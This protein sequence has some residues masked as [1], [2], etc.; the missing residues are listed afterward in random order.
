[1]NILECNCQWHFE[2]QSPRSQEIGPNNAAAEHFSAT[3]YPSLIRESIQNSLDVVRDESQPVKMKFE[4]GKM[5]AKTYEAFYEL[6]RHIEGVLRFYGSAAES[7]Y[8]PMLEHFEKSYNNQN[9]LHYIKVSDYNTVGMDYIHGDNN[10]PLYAFLRAEGV[11]VK[12]NEFSGGSF[13]FGKS[14][15]FMISPIHTVLVSTMT[16][17]GKSF[18]EGA[19]RL[20][21]HLY[22]G[23]DGIEKKYQHYGYYDNQRGERPA[24]LPTDIPKKFKRD[25]PGT[26]FYIMGMDGDSANQADAYDQMIKSTLRH[27][28]MAVM[29]HKLVVEIGDVLIDSD[30]LDALM[31][32]HFPSMLDK[33]RN[34]DEYNPRPYYEAV[35]NAGLNKNFVLVEKRLPYLGDAKL[36][37]W[38]NKEARDGV[39]H[40]RKQRMFIY[41]AR[42]YSSSYGYYA[43]FLCTDR[44][45]NKLLKSIEDP[46]HS[47]WEPRRNPSSGRIIM[48]EIKDFISDT[49]QEIFV[50]EHG[51]PL[52]ITGLEDYLFVPEELVATDKD[53]IADNSFFGEPSQELQEDGISPNTIIEPPTPIMASE[54]K[55]AVGKVITVTSHQGAEQQSGG[56]LGGHK[57]S[58]GKRKKKGTGESPDLTAFSPSSIGSEG[59]FLEN[60]PV[61]YR[62]MA[63]LK[64][65]TMIHTI[66]I[67]SDFDVERGQ[68]EIV[69]GGEENDETIDIISSSLGTPHGNI[70]TDLRLFK[71]RNNIVELRFADQMKHAIKLT[72]YEFK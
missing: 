71:N 69:V 7:E 9:I 43:V 8:R 28:W 31:Q 39:V 11:T 17:D 56:K 25:E 2:I 59:D 33:I 44:H 36:F 41:R 67:K 10:S 64:N 13:G 23:R 26:D 35:K 66:F 40:F 37:V 22:K 45:G 49:L 24:S 6:K 58:T 47:K 5:R 57:R 63:E 18:F 72:A 68:I 60:I 34:G 52:G 12:T 53:D 27:F 32:E 38:K 50:S 51:G 55:E 19:A 61:H 20:C 62:V 15:Y 30:S 42:F 54:R 4:F 46:S 21:T 65:G 70:V 16:E 29:H 14:A 3:P 48:D 1:M